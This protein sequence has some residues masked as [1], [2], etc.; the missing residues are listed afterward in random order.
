MAKQPK[1]SIKAIKN[2]RRIKEMLLFYAGPDAFNKLI[3]KDKEGNNINTEDMFTQ[4]EKYIQDLSQD[5]K[6]HD[7][8]LWNKFKFISK[9][10]NK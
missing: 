2:L 9:L 3:Y 1:R 10:G 6:E 5:Q 7:R 4:I 8:K